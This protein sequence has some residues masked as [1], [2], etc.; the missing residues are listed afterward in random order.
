MAACLNPKR[1]TMKSILTAIFAALLIVGCLI[2]GDDTQASEI[3]IAVAAN[4]TSAAKD[5]ADAFERQTGHKAILSFGSTGKLYTQ[6][7]HG[8]PFDAFLAADTKHPEMAE[9]E[10]LAVAGTRFT[11]ATGRIVLYSTDPTLVDDAG[12]V[13]SRGGFEKLAIANPKNAPYGAA[14]VKAMMELGVYD[15][16]L[17]KIVRGDNIAQTYQFVITGNAQLGFVALSQVVNDEAGS[18]W[19]VPEDIVA[20]I[21]QDAVLL[22]AGENDSTALAFLAFLKSEKAREIITRYGYGS[23]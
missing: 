10:G 17:P 18:K 22:R 7:T 23:D 4:F 15:T 5:I 1:P 20:P 19:I 21:R 2:K 3:N 9:Q 16:L 12:E 14:A 8:A 13:L 11:Y 6:I